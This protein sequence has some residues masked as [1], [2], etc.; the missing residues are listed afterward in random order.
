[1]T[2]HDRYEEEMKQT[3]LTTKSLEELVLNPGWLT[4]LSNYTERKLAR[5]GKDGE[6]LLVDTAFATDTRLFET[7]IVDIRYRVD[8]EFIIVDECK[9]KP[10]AKKIHKKW[11][12]ALTG[13]NLPKEIKDIHSDDVYKL[14]EN[15]K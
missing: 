7:G 1:M 2:N 4:M 14:I 9:T 13:L 3:K 10:E 12:V 5:F 11:V 15:S 6:N 8:G